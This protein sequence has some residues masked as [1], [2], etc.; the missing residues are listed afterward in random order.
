MN[1]V[2]LFVLISS[3][4]LSTDR[5]KFNM[6]AVAAEAGTSRFMCQR[7]IGG[8]GEVICVHYHPCSQE[9]CLESRG[10]VRLLAFAME[11]FAKLCSQTLKCFQVRSI[12]STLLE[13]EHP[14]KSL[15]HLH[16]NHLLEAC[17]SLH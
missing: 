10:T 14:E 11:R 17:G 7:L 1:L 2:N 3:L 15:L 13:Q 8:N 16:I 5:L 9:A 4:K 12:A 6:M